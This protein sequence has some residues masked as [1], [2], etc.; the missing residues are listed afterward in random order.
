MRLQRALPVIVPQAT[1][2]NGLN[3]VPHQTNPLIEN[4]ST[5]RGQAVQN[6]I[7]Y[8]ITYLTMPGHH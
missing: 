7:N 3:I 2:Y 6:H 1:A 8:E 5:G 4:R